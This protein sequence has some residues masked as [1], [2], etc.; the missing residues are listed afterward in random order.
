MPL[1]EICSSQSLLRDLYLGYPYLSDWEIC[2]L[3]RSTSEKQPVALNWEPLIWTGRSASD[4]SC[5]WVSSESLISHSQGWECAR[6]PARRWTWTL[7]G[8]RGKLWGSA[9]TSSGRQHCWEPEEPEDK[10]AEGRTCRFV[11][12]QHT[13]KLRPGLAHKS[14]CKFLCPTSRCAS[15]PSYTLYPSQASPQTHPPPSSLSWHN[16][17]DMSRAVWNGLSVPASQPLQP[18][19]SQVLSLVPIAVT[20]YHPVWAPAEDRANLHPTSTVTHE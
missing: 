7:H 9:R 3:T 17:P 4:Q 5:R 20:G 10:M 14:F 1:R 18:G 15:T 12:I 6:A 11:Q 2:M 19:S 16:V 13:P 8:Q